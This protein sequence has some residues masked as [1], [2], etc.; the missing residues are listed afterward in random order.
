MRTRAVA[1]LAAACLA[2]LSL[3]ALAIAAEAIA[4][5]AQY[6]GAPPAA[7][8]PAPAEAF[9]EDALPAVPVSVPVAGGGAPA[10][11]GR[12]PGRGGAA[13]GSGRSEPGL[14]GG[15]PAGRAPSASRIP[16]GATGGPRDPRAPSFSRHVDAWRRAEKKV[17]SDRRRRTHVFS[18]APEK[19]RNYTVVSGAYVAK[20]LASPSMAWFA[21][22][23]GGSPANLFARGAESWKEYA[24]RHA[25]SVQEPGE[26]PPAL[27]AKLRNASGVARE[28]VE[29][30]VASGDA[31]PEMAGLLLPPVW[32]V[33]VAVVGNDSPRVEGGLPHTVHDVV[34]LP[35]S[36]IAKSSTRDLAWLLVHEAAHVYQRLAPADARAVLKRDFGF[37]P[38]ASVASGAA[39][40]S[41]T[42][43]ELYPLHRLYRFSEPGASFSFV[44]R[45]PAALLPE[46]RDISQAHARGAVGDREAAEFRLAHAYLGPP[47][48]IALEVRANPDADALAWVRLVRRPESAGK[49]WP[50]PADAGWPGGILYVPTQRFRSDRP[51]FR[52]V[53]LRDGDDDALLDRGEHPHE[54]MAYA[55]QRIAASAG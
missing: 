38:A 8:R 15:L 37:V 35:R 27:L 3:S 20:A 55:W 11:T 30:A 46:W 12:L 6:P 41:A 5:G 43:L 17:V 29:A 25:A 40:D 23:V 16:A 36:A 32:P 53:R 10:H 31:P 33:R 9:R 47:P 1:A 24:A 2:A 51:G 4:A 28:A 7:A 48:A 54:V 45:H 13:R 26:V 18:F 22:A 50:G 42:D 49:I 39:S 14:V 52:D 21:A 34:V 19:P 44:P